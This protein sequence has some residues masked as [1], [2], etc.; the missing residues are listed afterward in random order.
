MNDPADQK[1][2]GKSMAKHAAV[3]ALI[4]LPVSIVGWMFG[5]V[6]GAGYA[7]YKAKTRG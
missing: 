3:G 6:V 5:A 2:L 4:A 7:F 1:A